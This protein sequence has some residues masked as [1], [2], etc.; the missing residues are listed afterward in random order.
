MKIMIYDTFISI[1][2]NLLAVTM[3]KNPS[4]YEAQNVSA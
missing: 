2:G 4:L 3:Y 1:L